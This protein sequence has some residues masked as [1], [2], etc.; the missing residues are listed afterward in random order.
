[1]RILVIGSGRVGSAAIAKLSEGNEVIVASRSTDPAVDVTNA[2]SIAALF[3]QIG[4]VDAVVATIGKVPFK[5]LTDFAGDDFVAAFNGKVLPQLEIVRLGTPFVRDGGSFT[6]TTGVLG[7]APVAEGAAAS[8]ANGAVD[9]FVMAATTELPRGIRINAV[10][11]TVL[12]SAT[13]QHAAFPGHIPASDE[14]V[15]M[16]YLRSVAGVETGKVFPV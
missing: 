13:H 7:R 10:S 6:L 1:M 2:E 16:S 8:M 11:P 9:A 5:P 14:A 3:A 4:D 12:E 15:G